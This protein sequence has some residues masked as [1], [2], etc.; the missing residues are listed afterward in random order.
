MDTSTLAAQLHDQRIQRKLIEEEAEEAFR[1]QSPT[2][3]ARPIEAP[4]RPLTLR[5]DLVTLVDQ[6]PATEL[7]IP[8]A[9]LIRYLRVWTDTL[10]GMVA[11]DA[12]WATLGATFAKR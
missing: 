1:T 2:S 8:N 3:P 7:Y 12:D 6:L 11:A 9:V 5:P 4:T 10:G